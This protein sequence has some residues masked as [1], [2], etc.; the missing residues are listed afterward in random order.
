MAYFQRRRGRQVTVYYWSKGKV[1]PLSRAETRHLD[2][3]RDEDI[4]AWLEKWEE[5]GGVP[6]ARSRRRSLHS[7][8]DLAKWFA[9]HMKDHE[10]YS[11]PSENT[12]KEYR[13]NLTYIEEYFV[14][15]LS[16]KDFKKWWRHTANFGTYLTIEK[17]L[18]P[19]TVRKICQSLSRFGKYLVM[20]GELSHPW[21]VRA[22]R[23]K[24][25]R[26]TPLIKK[27]TPEEAIGYANTLINEKRTIWALEALLSYFGSLRPEE[28]Y[29]LE[30]SDFITGVAARRDA[31]TWDRFQKYGLG[32]GLSIRIN[33][34]LTGPK[35][36]ELTKTHY[37]KG[38]VNIWHK[39]AAILIAGL[40]K[41]LGEGRLFEDWTRNQ[42][43]YRYQL[44]VKPLTGLNSGDRRRASANYLGKVIGLDPILLQDH[45]RHSELET[46][47]LYTRDPMDRDKE[48]GNQDFDDVG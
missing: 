34:T 25:K 21:L 12:M 11:Q 47:M 5:T 32:S 20:Q 27:L 6:R 3:L 14:K 33:K 10:A 28:V 26:Q 44:H 41:D 2:D 23:S 1:V 36:L 42:V 37:A 15:H 13:Y 48:T 29:A 40:L 8:D 31:K 9:S 43:N 16:L 46:T 18:Q 7:T 17:S 35:V 22:P 45:L 24:G 19:P 38:V 39:E 30:K 4:E